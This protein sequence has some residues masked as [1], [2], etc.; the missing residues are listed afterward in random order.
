MSKKNNFTTDKLNTENSTV[1]S[2]PI[3]QTAEEIKSIKQK[4]KRTVIIVLSIAVIIF[5]VLPW[6]IVK[7]I[8]SSN[9]D[10]MNSG[11]TKFTYSQLVERVDLVNEPAKT[12]YSIKNPDLKN[13]EAVKKVI[14]FLKPQEELGEFTLDIQCA[15]KPY[16][17]TFKFDLT[18][19]VVTEGQDEWELEMIKQS[20]AIMALMNNVA[21]VNWEFP[22][23]SGETKSGLFNRADAEKLMSL[24]V[25][26]ERFAESETSVQLL[27]NQ[28]GIDLY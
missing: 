1:F 22:I 3:R 9:K 24:N 4:R 28:L 11:Q 19:E 10:Y 6:I 16:N 21:Q 13:T 25:P 7:L 23:E 14:D 27:L 18:H 15:E 26:I 5:V 2:K 8:G 12:L 20:C 17:I